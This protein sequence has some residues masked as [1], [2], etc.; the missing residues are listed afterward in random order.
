ML[1]QEAF[2]PLVSNMTHE[3]ETPPRRGFLFS[4]ALLQRIAGAQKVGL[5]ESKPADQTRLTSLPLSF[6]VS[7]VARRLTLP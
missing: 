7:C 3:E 4:G 5:P 2:G 6:L 1:D